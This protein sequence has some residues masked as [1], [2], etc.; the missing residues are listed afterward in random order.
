MVLGL[1]RLIVV[2]MLEG[3]MLLICRGKEVLLHKLLVG[4]VQLLAVASGTRRHNLSLLS[5]VVFLT[6]LRDLDPQL[7]VV[8]VIQLLHCYSTVSGGY[9]NTATGTCSTVGGGRGN[10]ASG[11]YSTI[12]WWYGIIL[13][14]DNS[15]TV[16]GGYGHCADGNNAAIGGGYSNTVTGAC[17]TVSGGAENTCL[18]GSCSTVGDMVCGYGSRLYSM[19]SLIVVILL[20]DVIQQ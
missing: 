4:L 6:V 10:T 12:S 17:S 18:V 2:E 16:S 5:A 3:L 13:L 19:G 9:S 7:A 14:V 11:Y 1:Y 20:V 8:F 15:S